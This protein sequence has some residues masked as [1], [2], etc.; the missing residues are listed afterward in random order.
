LKGQGSPGIGG[1]TAGDLYLRLHIAPHKV[2]E[3]DGADLITPI[4]ISPWEAIL[5]TTVYVPT[6]NGKI[7]MNIPPGTQSEQRL[8]LR[9]KGLPAISGS[10][11]LYVIIKIAIPKNISNE[12]KELVEQLAG[13]S[14]FNPRERIVNSR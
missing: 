14:P 11:D 7:K 2:F 3:V 9:G 5:G 4:K 10:G 13:K 8:R 6:L 12:E 1:G